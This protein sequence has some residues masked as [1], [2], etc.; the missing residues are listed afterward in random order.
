MAELTE[1][2]IAA[3]APASCCSNEA[4]ES[5]CDPTEK[6][7]CCGEAAAGGSCGCSADTSIGEAEEIREAVRARYA[8]AATTVCRAQ[9]LLWRRCG[10]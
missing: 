7:S 8:A 10:P 4:Q 1:T 9:L 6:A 5:C 3:D 2:T